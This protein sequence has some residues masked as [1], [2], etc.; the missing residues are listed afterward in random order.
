[1][2][3]LLAR[4]IWLAQLACMACLAWVA[5]MPGGFGWMMWLVRLACMPLAGL[6]AFGWRD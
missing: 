6:A 4:L 5:C 3:F 2:E 1:M